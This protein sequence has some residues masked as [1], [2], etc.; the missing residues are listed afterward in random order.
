MAEPMRSPLSPCVPAA[1]MALPTPDLLAQSAC[2]D[3]A[4]IGVQFWAQWLT[5][6]I[7]STPCLPGVLVSASNARRLT[8]GL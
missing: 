4:L 6:S 3:T 2:V 1:A 5:V 7:G 8:T